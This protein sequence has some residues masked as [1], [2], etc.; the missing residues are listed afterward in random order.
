M[1]GLATAVRWEMVILI[2]GLIAVVVSKLFTG[3]VI[4]SGL[5]KVKGGDDEGTF[6]PARLQMLMSTVLAAMY[7][8]LQVINNRGSNS[9]P[10]VP[11]TLIG[12]L[13]GSHAIYLGGKVKSLQGALFGRVRREN[14]VDN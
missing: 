10:D 12:I 9:L 1:P 8:L 11:A 7:Y 3:G 4:L 6:S 2:G 14:D 13:G 5:L